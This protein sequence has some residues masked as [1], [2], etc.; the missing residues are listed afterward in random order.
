MTEQFYD[1]V[2][3]KFGSFQGVPKPL[4]I[5][6]QDNPEELF[7]QQLVLLG[8]KDKIA[9]DLGCGDGQFTLRMA[10]F[11]REMVGI[12]S[13]MERLRLAQAKQQGQARNHVRFEWQDASQTRF[14]SHTFDVVY[15]RRGPIPYQECARLTKPRGHFLTISIGEQDAWELKEAFGRGQGYRVWNSSA[16]TQAEECLQQVGFGVVAR[17]DVRYDEYFAS[18]QDLEVFLQAA[19]IFEDFDTEQ[20]RAAL[21]A[22]V[23]RF[24]T[25]Q[26]IHLPRHRFLVVALKQESN[27]W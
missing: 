10:T 14:E 23:S 9:L 24:Q 13:S 16:L 3:R 2:T 27:E 25:D 22:Y 17:H 5:Y 1:Q 18:Y 8:G 7:E 20:D 11:F 19:P 15:S 12:D 26:G 21:E 4:A 6:R